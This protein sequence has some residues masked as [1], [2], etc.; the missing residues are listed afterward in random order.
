[1][2][3]VFAHT[4]PAAAVQLA[5]RTAWLTFKNHPLFAKPKSRSL[6]HNM[7]SLSHIEELRCVRVAKGRASH[8]SLDAS[9]LFC[10]FRFLGDI[11]APTPWFPGRVLLTPC[12]QDGSQRQNSATA[13][14]SARRICCMMKWS[15]AKDESLSCWTSE[16]LGKIN[17]RP[18]PWAEEFPSHIKVPFAEYSHLPDECKIGDHAYPHINA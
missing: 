16:P 2:A 8:I 4:L 11:I 10:V 13:A 7:L 1:M 15:C 12:E 3:L 14:R 5:S 6:V 17:D 9:S 18:Q